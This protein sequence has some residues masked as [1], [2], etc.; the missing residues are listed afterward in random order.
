V[1]NG[2]TIM[3]PA[4]R[5]NPSISTVAGLFDWDT[6]AGYYQIGAVHPGCA[7][8]HGHGKTGQTK[9][10]SVPPPRTNL[11]VELRCPHLRRVPTRLRVRAGHGRFGT[12]MVL[13]KLAPRHGHAGKGQLAGTLT[14]ARGAHKLAAIPVNLRTGVETFDLGGKLPAGKLVVSYSGNGRYAPSR[15]RA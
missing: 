14:I 11:I 8:A 2:S 12:L 4:N 7:A 6:I 10:F 13:V 5:R 3:S 15:S 9:V 1:P